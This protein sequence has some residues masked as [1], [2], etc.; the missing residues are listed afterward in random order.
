V[1]RVTDDLVA[2]L[3][4]DVSHEPDAATVVLLVRTI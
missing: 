1:V 2:P 3:T 4:F